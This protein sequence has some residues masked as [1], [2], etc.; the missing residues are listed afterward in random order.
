MFNIIEGLN[1]FQGGG[2]GGGGGGLLVSGGVRVA[3]PTIV[4]AR[5][6]QAPIRPILG[7]SGAQ[8]PISRSRGGGFT[9]SLPGQRRRNFRT[10]SAAR[11]H[12]NRSVGVTVTRGGGIR[13]PRG[14]T[15][16][17]GAR[18]RRAPRG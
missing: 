12:V 9:V 15:V 10:Q 14:Q 16:L 7:L 2:G 17:P 13:V 8:N 1:E 4:P 18:G 5:A 3:D 11:Q 6:R